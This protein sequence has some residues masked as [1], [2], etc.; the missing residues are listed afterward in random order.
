METSKLVKALSDFAQGKDVKTFGGAKSAIEHNKAWLK[1]K[2]VWN[3]GNGLID[4]AAMDVKDNTLLINAP[5]CKPSEI[6]D[7]VSNLKVKFEF[8]F[9]G[10]PDYYQYGLHQV[11][12][13]YT[14]KA[15]GI[16]IP[17]KA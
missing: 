17:T 6:K 14:A 3:D 1:L 4:F 10:Y 2:R 12:G 11:R 5:F 7:I 13:K 16:K 9:L 8:V 15:W